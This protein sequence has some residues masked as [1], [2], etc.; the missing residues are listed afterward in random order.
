[1]AGEEGIR[2]YEGG[3]KREKALQGETLRRSV[4]KQGAREG[5]ALA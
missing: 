2:G 3:L 4:G 1:M 5:L